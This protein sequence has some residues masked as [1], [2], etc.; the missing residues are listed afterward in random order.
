MSEERIP[1]SSEA[2]RAALGEDAIDPA[3]PGNPTAPTAAVTHG[4]YL[5]DGACMMCSRC[6]VAKL[7]PHFR[8]GGDERCVIEQHYIGERRPQLVQALLDSGHKPQ[9]HLGLID[10]AVWAELRLARAMRCVGVRGEFSLG[11][12]GGDDYTGVAKQIPVLQA[13]VIK[14]LEALNLTPAAISKLDAA[15]GA[16]GEGGS[17][18]GAIWALDAQRQAGALGEGVTDA[19]FEEGTATANRGGAEGAEDGDGD[20]ED[21]NGEDAEDG[22]EA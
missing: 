17:I 8:E 6:P 22:D 10:S 7:C 19:E 2:F 21:G 12:K 9:L 1:D 4:V 13:A 14:A 11:G 15:R 20:G 3:G 18:A 16:G 5:A